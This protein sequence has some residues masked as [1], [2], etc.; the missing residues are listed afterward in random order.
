MDINPIRGQLS[1][2]V[3][4]MYHAA[5]H[6]QTHTNT[7]SL[8]EKMRIYTGELAID[9]EWSVISNS[10]PK[11]SMCRTKCNPKQYIKIK[12]D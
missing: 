1:T 6:T 11:H 2:L 4:F 5:K 3:N 10:I 7:I 9:L 8:V 12:F